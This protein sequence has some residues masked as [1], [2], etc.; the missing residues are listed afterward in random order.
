MPGRKR[1]NVLDWM[2]EEEEISSEEVSANDRL[3]EVVGPTPVQVRHIEIGK[4][5]LD[6][7]NPRSGELPDVDRLAAS[8]RER[9]RRGKPGLIQPI[10]LIDNKDGSFTVRVGNR[11]LAAYQ[12]LHQQYPDHSMYQRIAAMVIQHGDG[13]EE[14][15]ASNTQ[16]VPLSYEDRARQFVYLHDQL[17]YTDQEIADLYGLESRTYVNQ[18]RHALPD[19]QAGLR[20]FEAT[21]KRRVS[22]H[23]TVRRP[24]DGWRWAVTAHTKI[25]G[26]V[27]QVKA[28][29]A[30]HD[31]AVRRLR[32]I[33]DAA[34]SGLAELGESIDQA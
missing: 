16:M 12:Q 13:S 14:A 1:S 8:V 3:F 4:I 30:D 2:S 24:A 5:M 20:P 26:A 19:Y 33:R 34:T 28:G 31:E 17:G 15:L 32:E 27:Q 11:R 21:H 10:G 6:P 7:H 23:P 25:S 9:I 18:Q 22:D 29:K